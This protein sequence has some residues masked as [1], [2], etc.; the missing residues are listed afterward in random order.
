MPPKPLTKTRLRALADTRAESGR[1]ISVFLNLDPTE[2]STPP[3]RATAVA[4]L[5]NE[6]ETKV[7]EVEVGHDD[8]LRLQ[9][10]VELIKAELEREDLAEGGAQGVA[11]FANTDADLF[12]SFRLHH[13]IESRAEVD[14]TAYL[15]PLVAAGSHER[16]M[17][18]LANRSKARFFLGP[19]EGLEETDVL[20]N[21]VHRQHSAGGWSQARFERSV[22]EQVR[23]H[24]KSTAD[25]AF[26]IFKRR[27]F[28]KLLLAAPD[29]T[30]GDVEKHLH[31]YLTQRIA[32]TLHID[33][34]ASSAQ[35]VQAAASEAINDYRTKQ[36][37]EI[38]DRIAEH[39][40]RG[41]RGAA[42]LDAVLDALNMARVEILV[43]L[44]NL[45][46]PG[47]RDPQTEML[48]GENGD[49]P[50]GGA[51]EQVENIIEEAMQKAV[52]TNAEVIV[53]REHRE[54]IEQFGGVAALLRF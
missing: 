23:D 29:E 3:A 25:I 30:I 49:S 53:I 16:W 44:D 20:E 19:A 11:V 12:E 10:S 50:T 42:G 1:V 39:V 46:A 24:L 2:F 17:V 35:D 54:E 41:E 43:V 28:D 27:P 45:E 36:E 40:G 14:S 6:L 4:S 52:E 15:E 38:L 13:P 34:G 5:L 21:N 31:P 9:E 51:M 26:Q 32:G 37:R 47:T 22:D 8:R 18:L 33:I 48:A 7:G